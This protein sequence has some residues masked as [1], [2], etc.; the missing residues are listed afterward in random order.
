VAETR[1]CEQC[2]T[3]FVPRRE[4]AR[5]CSGGCRATWNREHTGDLKT[6]VSA[7]QWALTAMSETTERLLRARGHGTVSEHSR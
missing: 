7:L 6:G 1:A 3:S 5:F 2:G 4:H